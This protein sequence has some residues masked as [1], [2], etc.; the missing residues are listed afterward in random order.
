[1]N[2]Q[3]MEWAIGPRA[4]YY[5]RQFAKFE[6]AGA[7]TLPTW[8]W[9]A[10]L[11]ST[12]WFTYRR[13]DGYAMANF[14]LPIVFLWFAMMLAHGGGFLAWLVGGTY[15]VVAFVLIPMH[16]NGIYY[17]RLKAQ[18]ARATAP[19]CRCGEIVAATAPAWKLFSAVFCRRVCLDR[20][21]LPGRHTGRIRGLH[22]ARESARG[23]F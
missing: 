1:M 15:V 13:L 4:E 5:L 20:S 12:S 10:F 23:C 21:G 22:A 6:R 8:N 17:R 14:F 11:F 16:A 7:S 2:A 3:Q 19:E 9:P 18:F